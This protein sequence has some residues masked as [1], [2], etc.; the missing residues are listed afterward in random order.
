MISL[1]LRKDDFNNKLKENI[2]KKIN[3]FKSIC[4]SFSS[5]EKSLETSDSF[6]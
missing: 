3:S 6:N 2:D 1:G 5:L 4:E